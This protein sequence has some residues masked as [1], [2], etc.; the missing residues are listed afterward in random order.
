VHP[1][2]DPFSIE[3]LAKD[4]AEQLGAA[5]KVIPGTNHFWPY[6]NPEGGAALLRKFWSTL[7]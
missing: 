5:F 2:D 6:Q 1:S 3:A 7:D 4:V